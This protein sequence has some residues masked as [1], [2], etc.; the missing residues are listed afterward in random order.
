[1]KISSNQEWS[2]S[3]IEEIFDHVERIAKEKYGLNT[4]PNQLEIISS[5][6]M[7]DA[8]CSNG[9]P[10]YYPHWSYGEQY[11]KQLEAYRR[12]YMGLAYEIVI[13]S[14]PCISYLMEENT[15][16]MQTLVIAHAAFGHNHFFKNNYLFKQ[17]TDAEGIIDYLIYAKKFIRDCEESYG[18]DEVESVLDAAHTINYHGV[19]K[20]VRPTKLSAAEEEKLKKERNDY[21]QSQ[22]NDIWRTIPITK[23]QNDNAV[24]PERF[25]SEP[26]ENIL[27]F[28]EKNA[29]RLDTW[30]REIL[31]I[32]RK[33]SQYFYPQYQTKLMNE[34]TATYFHY[35][36]L[37]DLY[38]E[39]IIDDGAML[40][41]YHSHTNAIAQ[42][43]YKEQGFRA[44]F[45][46]YALGFAMFQD[47]ERITTNPTEEDRNW[48]YKQ[49][50]VG[51]N[52]PIETIKWAIENFKDESFIKQFL[53]PKIIREFKMFS[54]HDDDKDP[55][56]EVSGIHNERGYQTVREA[57]SNEYNI[58]YTIPDIQVFDVN[59]W[60]DR[61][62]TLRHYM[63]NGR[64]LDVESTVDTLKAISQLWGYEVKLES[65]N[66]NTSEPTTVYS[67]DGSKVTLD[68]FLDDDF[69]P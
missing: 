19:D 67:M 7:I 55:K 20:Y 38:D 39:G 40:E 11:V 26:Q 50:W 22:L 5:E 45:N 42:F 29:P 10:I 41:F 57:L 56:I 44:R 13:N 14:N 15:L 1:M 16:L 18:I 63:V 23:D 3:D 31:R 28:I 21:I 27:Y 46:P 48:F 62:L 33:I 25:P 68:V 54:I 43:G 4:Y 66:P 69:T 35:K 34:G 17:W 47:I 37:H 24:D 59:R 65:V 12:G 30:K 9:L 6:Q 52:K 2:F 51:N 64:P 8:Y 36:I 53:S 58:G 61:T 49:D 60:G 32:V